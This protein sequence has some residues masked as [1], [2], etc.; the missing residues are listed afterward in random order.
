MIEYAE[1]RFVVAKK[2]VG[3]NIYTKESKIRVAITL[4]TVN[5]EERTVFAGPFESKEQ[6][7]TFINNVNSQL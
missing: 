6:A 4:D 7:K 1:G 3:M 5:A 2:I